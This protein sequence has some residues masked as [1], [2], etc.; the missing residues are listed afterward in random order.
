MAVERGV[1]KCEENHAGSYGYPTRPEEPYDFC[2]QCGK[3]MMWE[4][5]NC[6]TPLP[7]CEGN[8]ETATDDADVTESRYTDVGGRDEVHGE[9][10]RFR[11]LLK[12]R[13]VD[14][15]RPEDGVGPPSRLWRRDDDPGMNAI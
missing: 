11:R 12:L 4:C 7:T 1:G 15:G 8:I 2:S 9:A 3:P 5:S 10:T 13:L 14:R 6:S